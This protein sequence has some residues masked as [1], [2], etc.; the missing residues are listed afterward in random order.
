M[1]TLMGMWGIADSLWMAL[2]RSS[3]SR[4]W[5]GFIGKIGGGDPWLARGMAAIQLA[6]SLAV[7]LRRR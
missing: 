5:G 2:D 4:F 3:W 6:V 1:L 7:V